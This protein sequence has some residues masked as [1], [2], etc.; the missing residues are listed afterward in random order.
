MQRIYRQT[1]LKAFLNNFSCI[2]ITK[3]QHVILIYIISD[4]HLV[5][6]K[7][8][9]KP[10]YNLNELLPIFSQFI[11]R[12]L[13]STV[14]LSTVNWTVIAQLKHIKFAIKSRLNSRCFNL[15]YQCQVGVRV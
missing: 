12:L 6:C 8:A 15:K 9:S 3:M 10:N 13:L 2:F 7:L 1:F 14:C 11:K 5:G 4:V